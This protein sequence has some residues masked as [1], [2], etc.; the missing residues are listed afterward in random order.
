ML[1]VK[2]LRRFAAEGLTDMTHAVFE[3]PHNPYARVLFEQ[4]WGPRPW[5]AL[6]G[7]GLF[8]SLVG[9]M[10]E[11]ILADASV[12]FGI[13]WP[14][15]VFAVLAAWRIRTVL[16]GKNHIRDH[17]DED[18]N[19]IIFQ[20]IALPLIPGAA[21]LLIVSLITDGFGT[22]ADAPDDAVGGVV[23]GVLAVAEGVESLLALGAV[24]AI[25]VA[26]LCF[27]RRWIRGLWKLLWRV[28]WFSILLWFTELVILTLAP[29]T[30]LTSIAV[31]T[32]VA[33]TL[34]ESLG[35]ILDGLTHLVFVSMIYLGVI[36]ALWMVAELNF[37]KLLAGEDINLVE[38]LEA[39]INPKTEKKRAKRKRKKKAAL[40]PAATAADAEVMHHVDVADAAE[41]NP[42]MVVPLDEVAETETDADLLRVPTRTT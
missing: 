26:T 2:K 5:V 21:V 24:I 32:V 17:F 8:S 28:L 3:V 14:V 41:V 23:G 6:V 13:Y 1:K 30:Q 19:R 12:S 36:G 7:V 9:Y 22:T 38:R 37:P 31:N 39:R 40:P 11:I 29:W 10:L 33:A 42:A 4:V 25:V 35:T 16:L 18:D 20:S 15:V 27:T 34:P